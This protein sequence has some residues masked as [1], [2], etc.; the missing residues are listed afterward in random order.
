MCNSIRPPTT[1]PSSTNTSLTLGGNVTGAGSLV[2]S[3][4]GVLIFTG[5]ASY[6]GGTNISQATSVLRLGNEVIGTVATGNASASAGVTTLVLASTAGLAA[7]DVSRGRRPSNWLT[8]ILSITGTTISPLSTPTIGNIGSSSS[9]TYNS[10]ATSGALSGNINLVG[11]LAFNRSDSVNFDPTNLV[12]TTTG[13]TLSQTGT[14]TLTLTT[15]GGVVPG[16]AAASAGVIR[17]G[18]NGSL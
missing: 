12:Q 7:T 18:S 13:G 9:F 16:V 4:S 15:S 6:T 3:G 14:G 8:T 5:N 11:T 10:I 1:L 17:L 2:L